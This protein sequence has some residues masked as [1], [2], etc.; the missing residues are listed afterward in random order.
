MSTHGE[1][2]ALHLESLRV[3]NKETQPTE[4]FLVR[5][6]PIVVVEL[7]AGAE[8]PLAPRLKKCLRGAALNLIPESILFLVAKG[9]NC[10]IEP[11]HCQ[12]KHTSRDEKRHSQPV[13]A[14]AARL[15]RRHFIVFGQHAQRGEHGNKRCQ[16]HHLVNQM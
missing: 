13:K 4:N 10:G 11:E 3:K 15:E 6:E 14:C 1:Y 2:S 7:R 9:K 12:G 8:D 5:V 16:R